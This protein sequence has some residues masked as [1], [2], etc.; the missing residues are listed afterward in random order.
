LWDVTAKI[1]DMKTG[2]VLLASVV[3]GGGLAIAASVLAGYHWYSARQWD[4]NALHARFDHFEEGPGNR[5]EFCYEL[6]NNTA[7]DYYVDINSQPTLMAILRKRHPFSIGYKVLVVQHPIT[8]PAGQRAIAKIS[9]GKSS[10]PN[11][12]SFRHNPQTSGREDVA[13]F[14]REK[15]GNL[16]GFVLYDLNKRYRISFPRAW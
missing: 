12:A 1:T 16:D 15:Y 6:Q 4:K 10:G 7:S 5:I 11:L 9:F 13:G 14:V 3:L 2:S 8:V